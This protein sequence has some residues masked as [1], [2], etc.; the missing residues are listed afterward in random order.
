MLLQIRLQLNVLRVSWAERVEGY[1]VYSVALYQ[2]KGILNL[3]WTDGSVFTLI[4]P[5]EA[6]VILS[7]ADSEAP[8]LSVHP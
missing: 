6:F 7:Y 5:Q 8:N 4:L 1:C 2:V 3:K